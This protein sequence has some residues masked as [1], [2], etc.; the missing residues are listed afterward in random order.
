[1]TLRRTGS[2][3]TSPTFIATLEELVRSAFAVRYGGD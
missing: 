2:L 1:V 3:N